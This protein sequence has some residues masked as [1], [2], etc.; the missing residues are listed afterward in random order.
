[1]TNNTTSVDGGAMPEINR[2][3]NITRA[4]AIIGRRCFNA[5]LQAWATT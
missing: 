5:C 1:M 2:A 4:W 3:T